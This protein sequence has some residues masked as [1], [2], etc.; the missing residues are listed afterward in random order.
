MHRV[1][2]FSSLCAGM[3]TDKSG[4][5][6]NPDIVLYSWHLTPQTTALQRL[7]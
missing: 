6:G 5:M 2:Y 1:I 7:R 3:A 4:F